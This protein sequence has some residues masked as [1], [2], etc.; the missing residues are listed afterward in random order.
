MAINQRFGFI[1]KA[2]VTHGARHDGP[3]L[4]ELATTNNTAS[5]VWAVTCY[6]SKTNEA[7]PA[8]HGR[9]SWTQRNKST[10]KP[11]SEA[12]RVA[13]RAK[14]KI[15]ARMEYVF[16][17]QKAHMGL[18]ISTVSIKPEDNKIMLANFA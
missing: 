16:A 10:G 1:R 9:V 2:A 8:A 6:R 18:F 5:D 13:N 15:R 12:L 7:W 14:S 4:R 3:Q 17:Q 11:R